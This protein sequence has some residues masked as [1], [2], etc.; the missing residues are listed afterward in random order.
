MKAKKEFFLKYLKDEAYPIKINPKL[1]VE[2]GSSSNYKNND[3]NKIIIP[4]NKTKKEKYTF[5]KFASE[6]KDFDYSKKTKWDNEARNYCINLDKKENIIKLTELNQINFKNPL[7]FLN[8]DYF[9]EKYNPKLFE[10]ELINIESKIN[11]NKKFLNDKDNIF[12]EKLMEER[13]KFELYKKVLKYYLD[14]Y[15]INNTEIMNP[16][17]DKIRQLTKITDFYYEKLHSKK[18]EILIMKRCNIDNAMKLILKKKKMANLLKIYSLFKHDIII[19][20]NGLKELKTKKMN[21]DFISYYKTINK[22]IDEVEKIDK[23]IINKLNKENN[24]IEKN[25]KKL[26]L[27]TEVKQKLIN[28]KEKFNNKI[29]EEINNIFESKKSYIF[30][31]YYLFD[32]IENNQN[33]NSKI[34]KDIFFINKMKNNFKKKSKIIILESLQYIYN[35]EYTEKKSNFIYNS[36]N[37]KLSSMNNIIINEKLLNIYFINIFVKLKN[38]LDVFLYYYNSITLKDTKEKEYENFKN[39]FKSIKNDF[40][41]ILDKHISKT[42]ILIE[43]LTLSGNESLSISKKNIIYIINLICLFEKLLKIKF[44]VKYNKF[45][46]LALKNYLIN[47]FKFENKKI[48]EKSIILLTNNSL[49]KKLLDTSI[50]QIDSIREQT[51]FYL[52]RFVSFFNES[53]IKDSWISKL[54]NKNNIDDIFNIIINNEEYNINNLEFKYKNFDEIIILFINEEDKEIYKK[55]IDNENNI[56]IFNQ[57]LKENTSYIN[58]SSFVIIKGIVEQII[59]I[60]IFESQ[61]FEI[62]NN[63]FDTIDLYIFIIFKLFII[64]SR[65]KSEFL[66]NINES[67]LEKINIDYLSNIILFHKKFSDLKR[68]Y[69]LYEIKIKNYFGEEID[70]YQENGNNFFESLISNFDFKKYNNTKEDENGKA[71]NNG[72]NIEEKGSETKNIDNQISKEN[73]NINKEEDIE[74][75]NINEM[76]KINENNNEE[77][78][79]LKGKKIFSFF[80]D[81]NQINNEKEKENENIINDTKIENIKKVIILISCIFTIKKILKRLISFSTKIELELERYEVLCKINKYEKLLEQIQ[82]IFYLE[83]ITN[84]FDFSE[85]SNLIDNYNWAPS[86]EE[87]SKK[88]FDASDWVKKLKIYFEK[89]ISEIHNKLFEIFGEKKLS[90]FFNVLLKYIINLIQENFS[91]IKKCNDMGRSIM[92]KDIKLLKEGFNNTL[93]KYGTNKKIK[94][95]NIFDVIIQYANAWYYNCDE[96][97]QYIFNYNLEYKYFENIFNSSPIIEQLTYNDKNDFLKKVKQNFLNKFKKIISGIQKAN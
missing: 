58:N 7:L 50:F 39:E 44:N 32:I 9:Q 80:N 53:E 37:P 72:E 77:N 52:K 85:I 54:I 83:I 14:Y 17:I 89:I 2:N 28:K 15:C 82:N 45:I 8:K 55:E 90:E 66:K 87:G 24:G 27:M 97:Y 42:I 74:I 67:D 95:E 70:I 43:N 86:P 81:S 19:I 34:S 4:Q 26:N 65:Y 47:T 78:N 31:L 33:I 40:Y 84:I 41:E 11:S 16:P 61:I 92:L 63:L 59:N 48:L 93:K 60:I 23:N 49:E 73:R 21:Y 69:N 1:I 75:L 10:K 25:I 18:K 79:I 64:E 6:I 71:S 35:S 62:F 3:I 13:E 68:F 20:F 36:L 56:I 30:D 51:P 76:N 91:Q 12:I 94:I 5:E 46:N 57:P 29:N 96:L 88:L 22:L 38:L